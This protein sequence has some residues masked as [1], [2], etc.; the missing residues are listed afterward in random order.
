MRKTFVF[1]AALL[2]VIPTLFAAPN[3]GNGLGIQ[4]GAGFAGSMS[5][6]EVGLLLPK[7]NDTVF[8]NVKARGMSAITWTTFVNKDTGE[9]ASF[10]PVTVGGSIGVGSVGPLDDNG[11]RMYGGSDFFFGYTFTPYDSYFYNTGNLITPNL[12][13][14]TWGYF[15]FEYF[16]SDTSSFFIQSGGGYKGLMVKDK[17][18]IYAV[19]ASWL[20]S[21][22]GIEMGSSIYLQ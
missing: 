3:D 15:G 9:T 13:F 1:I 5:Y 10:H 20:G 6:M 22:F 14:A 11:L 4:F 2:S 19:A 21:G 8:I 17:K 12:T 7:I 18:N 16:T